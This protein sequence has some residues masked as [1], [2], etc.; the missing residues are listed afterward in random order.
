MNFKSAYIKDLVNKYGYDL[1][2]EAVNYLPIRQKEIFIKTYGKTLEEDVKIQYSSS[3]EQKKNNANLY[4]AKKNMENILIK[5]KAKEKTPYKSDFIKEL[6][7]LHGFDLVSEAVD[8]LPECQKEAF[9]LKHTHTLKED[10]NYYSSNYFFAKQNLPIIIERI[11]K[12]KNETYKNEFIRN[13]VDLYGIDLVKLAV[14]LLPPQQYETM[15]LRHG[16]NLCE[17]N[18][19]PKAPFY[20]SR[21][22][23]TSNYSCAKQNIVHYL[24]IL[25]NINDEEIESIKR[26][27]ANIKEKKEELETLKKS[28]GLFK[29]NNKQNKDGF[30]K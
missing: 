23:Y 10:Y 28:L 1:T 16:Q 21:T 15:I 9:Y 14:N 13:L 12:L 19:L 27:L 4:Y 11:K 25:S 26:N 2:L 29:M 20:A 17:D 18:M 8:L 22:F 5:L 3:K 7:D 24:K 6:V 30:K